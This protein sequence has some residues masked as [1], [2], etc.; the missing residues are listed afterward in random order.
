MRV[1]LLVTDAYGGHGGIAYYNRCL[2]EALAAMPE[3]EEVVVLPRV[4]RF[5]P[6]AVPAKIN[7]M[8][9]A[10]GTKLRYLR[11]LACLI[12]TPFDVVICGHIHL[13]PAAAPFASAKRLPLV[14]QVHGIE[15]GS[16]GISDA[17]GHDSRR[18][19]LV[20]QWCHTETHER[21]GGVA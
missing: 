3:V 7:F 21:L 20:S 17:H 6:G 5:A 1:L 15:A 10:A 18:L 14:L 4:M 9:G 13:L 19:R 11:S 2:S 12:A 8:A 16:A